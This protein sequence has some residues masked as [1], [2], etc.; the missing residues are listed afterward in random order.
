MV[1]GTMPPPGQVKSIV[2]ISE[3]DRETI[4]RYMRHHYLP[5]KTCNM[6]FEEVI[7][8][9]L[10]SQELAVACQRQEG[11]DQ[12]V[13]DLEHIEHMELELSRLKHQHDCI[14]EKEESIQAVKAKSS[15]IMDRFESC[16][17]GGQFELDISNLNLTGSAHMNI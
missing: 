4:Q 6:A 3:G 11:L 10:A 12:N 7:A 1:L 15:R 17:R 8:A 14:L 9:R 2:A 13:N 5:W 16:D